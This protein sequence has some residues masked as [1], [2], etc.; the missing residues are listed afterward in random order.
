MRTAAL[1]GTRSAGA[2]LGP[3]RHWRNARTHTLHDTAAWKIQHLGHR[4]RFG[5]LQPG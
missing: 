4:S 1:A 5:R 3:D 2:G